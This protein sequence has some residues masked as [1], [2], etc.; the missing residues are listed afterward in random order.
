LE[1]TL[2]G[3]IHPELYDS[4]AWKIHTDAFTKY[5]TPP[6]QKAINSRNPRQA[7]PRDGKID[8][9]VDGKLIGNWFKEGTKGYVDETNPDR[10]YYWEGHLAIVPDLYDPTAFWVSIGNWNNEAAQFAVKGN[11]P[12]PANIG[13]AKQ[14]TKYE[15]VESQYLDGNGNSWDRKSVV[16]SVT[17]K[18][19]QTVLGVALFQLLEPRKLKAQFFPGKTAGQ[20]S[21]FTDAAWL[22]YR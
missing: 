1:V 19:R 2:K 4:E 7:E 17:M 9:D 16:S 14:P 21:G 8:Y 3:F 18:P 20:V 6:L 12:N 10:S 15:L 22:Y 11:A 13:V 5:F